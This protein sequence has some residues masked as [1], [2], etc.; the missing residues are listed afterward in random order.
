MHCTIYK[1]PADFLEMCH[2][3]LEANEVL[4]NLMLGIAI[5]LSDSV[6]YYGSEPFLATV[7]DKNE[8]CLA[9]LM[10]PPYKVQIALFNT[11]SFVSISLLISELQ[12]T[13]GKSPAFWARKI[14]LEV[15]RI[16][17]KRKPV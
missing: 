7:S 3:A 15:S 16:N 8:L 2:P 17:G 1:N 9:A 13:T 11:N 14:P 6:Q 12:K 10:T 4:Y 5:R